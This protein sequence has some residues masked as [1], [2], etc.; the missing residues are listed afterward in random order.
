MSCI[1][2]VFVQSRKHYRFKLLVHSVAG[3]LVVEALDRMTVF[4]FYPRV[5]LRFIF[6]QVPLSSTSKLFRRRFCGAQPTITMSEP[7]PQ[8]PQGPVRP[9][10]RG[11]KVRVPERLFHEMMKP[12]VFGNR[13]KQFTFFTAIASAGDNYC[14]GLCLATQTQLIVQITFMGT[15]RVW[16]YAIGFRV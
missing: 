9:E 10:G 1:I 7:E 12:L 2:Y 15:R 5:Q 6:S 8:T 14:Y 11:G 3:G 4:R 16:W 13:Q